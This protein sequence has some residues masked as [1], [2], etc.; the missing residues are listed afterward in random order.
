MTNLR[1]VWVA[2]HV[3]TRLRLGPQSRSVPT[4]FWLGLEI[5]NHVSFQLFSQQA[6]GIHV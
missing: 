4:A 5:E 1:A 3:F 2:K 6:F